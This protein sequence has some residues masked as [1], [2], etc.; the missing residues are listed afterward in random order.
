MPAIMH[1]IV[2]T[3]KEIEDESGVSRNRVSTLIDKLEKM[4]ILVSDSTYA[5]LGY[6][7]NEIYNVFV[8]KDML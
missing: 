3:K 5:K 8:G 6:K 1:Q 4:G 2:F 7:Y